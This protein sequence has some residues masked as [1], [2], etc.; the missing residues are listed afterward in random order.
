MSGPRVPPQQI[1]LPPTSTARPLVAAEA[2]I[3][4]LGRK[5]PHALE[6]ATLASAAARIEP[7]LLRALRLALVPR[8]DSSA[9]A[10]LWLGPAM[11]SRSVLF[12]TMRPDV[13]AIL[14]ERL[15]RD[16]ERL[17]A[18]RR[19]IERVHRDAPPAIRAEEEITWRALADPQDPE[20]ARV[21]ESVSSALERGRT[22]LA[23]WAARALPRMPEDAR[24]SAPAWRVALKA[25]AMLGTAPALINEGTRAP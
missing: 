11:S 15:A 25:S 6:L 17:D 24:T 5:N 7:E 12:A 4:E 16:R 20:L 3:A 8:A 18:A 22:G 10:D 14:R 9:E 1:E 13:A 23:R 19:A 2:C 21:F